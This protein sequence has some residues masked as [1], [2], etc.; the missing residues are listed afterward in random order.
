[1]KSGMM[2]ISGVL[3]VGAALV[4]AVGAAHDLRS[5]GARAAGVPE[6]DAGGEVVGGNGPRPA[7]TLITL[8]PVQ[9][10][11]VNK[12]AQSQSYGGADHLRAGSSECPGQQ[13]LTEGHT[14][15]CGR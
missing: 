13:N 5:T 14:G 10:T 11:W 9:D 15:A 7:A 2:R 3:L 1:M 6:R 12:L 4:L 8:Y